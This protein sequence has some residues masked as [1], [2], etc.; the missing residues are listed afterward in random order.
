MICLALLVLAV[1]V[2]LAVSSHLEAREWNGGRCR[3]HGWPW[4]YFDTDSQGGNGYWCSHPEHLDLCVT[5]QSW[6]HD[7]ARSP[8]KGG[9]GK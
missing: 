6:G 3:A 8:R 2:G 1:S 4:E 5:W 7:A 9:R